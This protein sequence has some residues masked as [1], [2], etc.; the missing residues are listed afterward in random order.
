[1]LRE[2]RGARRY[3]DLVTLTKKT[4][5][6]DEFG[7]PHF[8]APEDV[9]DVYA[10]V[11]QMSATKSMLTFQQ[12]DVIGIDIEMREPGVAFDGLTWRGHRVYFPTPESVDNRGRIIRI[13]GWYQTDNPAQ[14]HPVPNEV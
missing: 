9:L 6:T 1:M 12:A 8:G 5:V 11:R 14:T 13:S 4:V 7:H 10:Q 3:N 2:S